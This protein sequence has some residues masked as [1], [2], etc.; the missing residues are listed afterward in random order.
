MSD[1]LPES[2]EDFKIGSGIRVI[3]IPVDA[4][5][6]AFICESNIPVAAFYD[7]RGN[8]LHCVITETDYGKTKT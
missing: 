6:I 7:D 1:K 2:I 8:K 3:P 4:V 5:Y